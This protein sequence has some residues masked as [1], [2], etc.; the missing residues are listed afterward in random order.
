MGIG[1]V[2]QLKT[3]PSA[4]ALKVTLAAFSTELVGE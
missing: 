4:T 3:L 2:G 1:D